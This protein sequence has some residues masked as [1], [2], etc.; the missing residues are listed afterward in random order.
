MV[1]I[2]HSH[3]VKLPETIESMLKEQ[4]NNH[5]LLKLYI[6]DKVPLVSLL[7]IQVLHLKTPVIMDKFKFLLFE[8]YSNLALSQSEEIPFLRMESTLEYMLMIYSYQFYL[9]HVYII[10]FFSLK[11]EKHRKSQSVRSSMKI[12]LILA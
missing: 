11:K 9:K 5:Y 8:V 4:P 1:L 7:Y 10:S 2:D 12:P 6:I 3:L